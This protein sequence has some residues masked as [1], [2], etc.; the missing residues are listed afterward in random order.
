MNIA[1]EPII[2][3]TVSAPCAVGPQVIVP[4]LRTVWKAVHAI[5][6]ALPDAFIQNSVVTRFEL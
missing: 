1:L 3:A 5:A 6:A 2:P 4:A